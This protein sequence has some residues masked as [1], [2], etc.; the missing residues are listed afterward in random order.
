MLEYE[1]TATLQNGGQATATANHSEIAFDATSGRDNVLPNPAE[2]L[3]TS[4]A[5]CLLKNVQRYSEILHIP[6]RKAR[7]TIHGLRNENPPFMSEINYHIE[8]DSEANEHQMNN[9]HKNILKF[10]TITNTLVRACKINGKMTW[11]V[12]STENNPL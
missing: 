2:L 12:D 8:V 9:W 6:Y 1:I 4:L 11:W 5:A 3:L 10:G 7:V